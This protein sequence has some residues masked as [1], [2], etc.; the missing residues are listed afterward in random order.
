MDVYYH[1]SP[2]IADAVAAS[3]ALA[4]VVRMA[5]IPVIVLVSLPVPLLAGLALLMGGLALRRIV[6]GR[7]ENRDP[8]K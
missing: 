6:R 4:M 7:R 5:L 2:A 8:A 1:V 3:P